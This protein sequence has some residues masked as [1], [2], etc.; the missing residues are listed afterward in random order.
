MTSLS[1]SLSTRFTEPRTNPLLFAENPDGR[2]TSMTAIPLTDFPDHLHTYVFVYKLTGT[3]FIL[4]VSFP[5]RLR[6]N[7]SEVYPRLRFN[8][9]ML[10]ILC[11]YR[12]NFTYLLISGITNSKAC[13]I[14]PDFTG[15]PCSAYNVSYPGFQ[16][17]PKKWTS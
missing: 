14:S 17:G 2:P 3:V 13:K 16:I 12:N 10:L 1:S 11:A 9:F 6:T 7:S 15:I 5:Q 8:T 4:D